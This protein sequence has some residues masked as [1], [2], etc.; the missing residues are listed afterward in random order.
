MVETYVVESPPRVSSLAERVGSRLRSYREHIR[1]TPVAEQGIPELSEIY[2]LWE[3]P[4][5]LTLEDELPLENFGRWHVQIFL[6]GQPEFYARC[7]FEERRDRW[8]VD[9]IGEAWL[10]EDIDKGAAELEN[11]ESQTGEPIHVRL[12]SSRRFRFSAFW[13]AEPNRFLVVSA[14]SQALRTGDLVEREALRAALI[15][16]EGAMGREV[17]GRRAER[18]GDSTSLPLASANIV[19]PERHEDRGQRARKPSRYP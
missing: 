16:T 15:E 4:D 11:I 3:I 13:L 10:A 6:G 14:K 1:E 17:R 19:R 7:A 2:P 12:V 9:W 18:R 5:G 8:R